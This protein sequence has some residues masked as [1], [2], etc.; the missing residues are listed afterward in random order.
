MIMEHSIGASL[1][2]SSNFSKK[3][4]ILV[5]WERLIVK[6]YI[7]LGLSKLNE[8]VVYSDSLHTFV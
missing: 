4:V 2:K 1:I 8:A 3:S 5:D 7:P 6:M